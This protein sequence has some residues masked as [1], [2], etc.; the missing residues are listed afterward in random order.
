MMAWWCGGKSSEAQ[1]S[2][3]ETASRQRRSENT[4]GTG[5]TMKRK[6]MTVLLA[7]LCIAGFGGC[8][9]LN[10]LDQNYAERMK[11]QQNETAPNLGR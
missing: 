4:V 1:R 7:V 3:S 5:E 6:L 10:Q 9:G 2:R 11:A 8:A